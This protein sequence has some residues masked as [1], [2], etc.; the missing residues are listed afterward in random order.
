MQKPKCALA[1]FLRRRIYRL[2]VVMGLAFATVLFS[3]G[4]DLKL[5]LA[6]EISSHRPS[7]DKAHVGWS[8]AN[9][10]F[11]ASEA[12]LILVTTVSTAEMPQLRELVGVRE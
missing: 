12:P 4:Q 8:L 5:S 7:P 6:D 11:A 9:A 2:A 1:F 3:L 10:T